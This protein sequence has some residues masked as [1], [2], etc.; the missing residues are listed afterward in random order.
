ML[1][2]MDIKQGSAGLNIKEKKDGHKF[3]IYNNVKDITIVVDGQ[4]VYNIYF[5]RDVFILF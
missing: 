2:K 4:Y 5:Y 1:Y 3:Q